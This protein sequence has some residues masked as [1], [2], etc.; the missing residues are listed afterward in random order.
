MSIPLT[1]EYTNGVLDLVYQEAVPD[2]AVRPLQNFPLKG[3]AVTYVREDSGEVV[4]AEILR[5]DEAFTEVVASVEA[6]G[7][8][9]RYDVPQMRLHDAPLEMVLR[10]CYEE[11][12]QAATLRRFQT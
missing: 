8:K 3:A 4:G 9:S 5:F 2:S 7:L 12:V 6:L 10:C 11:Y 1:V